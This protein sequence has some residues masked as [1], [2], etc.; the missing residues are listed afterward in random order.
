VRSCPGGA[1]RPGMRLTVCAARPAGAARLHQGAGWTPGYPHLHARR[2]AALQSPQSPE[3]RARRR[4][5]VPRPAA[6]AAVAAAGPDGAAAEAAACAHG[7]RPR[8]PPQRCQGAGPAASRDSASVSARD[9]ARKLTAHCLRGRAILAQL[10]L[11]ASRASITAYAIDQARC[12]GRSLAGA[13][14]AP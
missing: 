4:Q 5:Q 14:A 8:R 10:R 9:A 12:C 6:R 13:P 11:H 2:C 7:A 1:S 3:C